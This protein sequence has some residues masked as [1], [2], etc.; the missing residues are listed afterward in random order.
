MSCGVRCYFTTD[1]SRQPWVTDRM[2]RNVGESW[3][4]IIRRSDSSFGLDL[5]RGGLSGWDA[6]IFCII[7]ITHSREVFKEVCVPL[8]VR[9]SSLQSTSLKHQSRPIILKVPSLIT[10]QLQ[11]VSRLMV[12]KKYLSSWVIRITRFAYPGWSGQVI[13][14]QSFKLLNNSIFFLLRNVSNILHGVLISM[15]III[16]L[17]V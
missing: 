5:S 2:S 13:S 11:T 4:M 3:K 9:L 14:Q 16:L 12:E 10:F 8:I 17:I 15:K 1:V 6:T 7:P